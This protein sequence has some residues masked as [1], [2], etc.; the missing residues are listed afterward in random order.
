MEFLSHIEIEN[1]EITYKKLLKD[2]LSDVAKN[3]KA[4]VKEVYK[5]DVL[6]EAGYIVGISH[7]FGK[8]TTFFQEYL[9]T[10]KSKSNLEWHSF[11]SAVFAAYLMENVKNNEG[12]LNSYL[13]LL[14]YFAV[15]H[16]HGNL[17][18]FDRDVV[19]I[20]K[21]SSENFELVDTRMRDKLLLMEPQIV[22][23]LDHKEII[24]HE[25]REVFG[26]INLEDFKENW[27]RVLKEL[28]RQ[29][30]KLQKEED[31]FKL[32]LNTLL[33][34]IY[35]CLI[36]NDK[37]D[38][39]K[40]RR[41]ERKHIPGDLVDRYG[42]EEFD[43]YEKQGING[44]RNEIYDKVMNKISKVPLDNRIFTLTAPTGTGKTISSFSVALKLRE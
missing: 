15:L 34:F 16:H 4:K 22:N 37:R 2:H 43:I 30:Y 44:I 36:D 9:R 23:L 1:K 3:I 40:V 33:L 24:E 17:Y 27:I 12:K 13:P 26:Q 7:D 25:Y 38:A 28:H 8:Y 42:K 20:Q 29:K 10:G 18:S 31:N 5:D 39:A 21:L 41:V 6:A 11:I 19:T 35:S 14:S 32:K